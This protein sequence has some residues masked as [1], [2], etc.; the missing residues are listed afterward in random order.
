VIAVVDVGSKWVVFLWFG[1]LPLVLLFGWSF[2]SFWISHINNIQLL[3]ESAL[4]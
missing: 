2:F 3:M 4:I 1:R